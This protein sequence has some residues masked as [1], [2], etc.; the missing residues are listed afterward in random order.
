MIYDHRA[1][2]GKQQTC[3]W[4]M[5]YWWI[6]SLP[7]TSF[8]RSPAC[9]RKQQQQW[10]WWKRAPRY[11]VITGS[12][13]H[14]VLWTATWLPATLTLK[15]GSPQDI[16]VI[17]RS[18]LLWMWTKMKRNKNFSLLTL[19]ADQASSNVFV[20]HVRF[21]QYNVFLKQKEKTF[22]CS[23][24]EIDTQTKTY[25]FVSLSCHLFDSETKTKCCVKMFLF[26]CVVNDFALKQKQN[27]FVCFTQFPV[28]WQWNKNKMFLFHSV[29]SDLAVKQKLN[30][31]VSL[32]LYFGPVGIPYMCLIPVCDYVL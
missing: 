8:C 15:L 9:N 20:S 12:P 32:Q 16:I 6:P 3:S 26:H 10:L 18:K 28:I 7:T 2:Y 4:R 22:F 17:N 11:T 31:F 1:S 25:V 14:L 24:S 19:I 13:N 23:F 27:V 5:S 29:F 30:V 21:L